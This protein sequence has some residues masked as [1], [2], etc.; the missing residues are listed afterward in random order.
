MKTTVE[1]VSIKFTQKGN[2]VIC[3]L[4]SNIRF[5]KI[6]N[7]DCFVDMDDVY[8]FLQKV[9]DNKGRYIVHTRGVAKCGPNDVFDYETGKRLAHTRAQIKVFEMAGD[10]Y[11]EICRRA[12]I[13]LD[14][15]STNCI[16][17]M[18]KC[19]NHLKELIEN[20]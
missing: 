10:F 9:C 6:K 13:D 17:S 5:D 2:T 12:I 3:D 16:V 20:Q 19:E 1:Y 11:D 8:T 15:T 4:V 18:F 7:M 14:N